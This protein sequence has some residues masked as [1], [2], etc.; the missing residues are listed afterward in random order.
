MCRTPVYGASS[1]SRDVDD[2]YPQR[3]RFAD[4][5]GQPLGV[6][7]VKE[8]VGRPDPRE[9]VLACRPP[10]EARIEAE[11]PRLALEPRSVGPVAH[12]D[13]ARVPPGSALLGEVV[14]RAGEPL[15]GYEATHADHEPPLSARV[16]SLGDMGGYI[17]KVDRWS[18]DGRDRGKSP[19]VARGQGRGELVM[20]GARDESPSAGVAK[21]AIEHG[22][23]S[24]GR[25]A[26]EQANVSS[27][28]DDLERNIEA[29]RDGKCRWD[30]PVG[31]DAV[32]AR[33]AAK[34]CPRARDPAG[35]RRKSKRILPE[36][37]GH[38]GPPEGGSP[39]AMPDRDGGSLRRS[40]RA[41]RDDENIGL[42]GKATRFAL[43]EVAA[44][45]TRERGVARGDQGDPHVRCEGTANSSRA[46]AVTAR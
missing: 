1:C 35:G 4:H 42:M 33:L 20:E 44:R 27:V 9:R 40:R 10:D 34:E 24:G 5:G 17:R 46:S 39:S 3:F 45:I 26:R 43:H 15:A 22:G 12:D 32:E 19:P 11:G 13:D 38:A 14:E 2:R 25:E 7:R 29:E 28:R 6:R 21:D 31:H 41:G 16:S 18:R 23:A 36:A 37:G 30:R 8:T